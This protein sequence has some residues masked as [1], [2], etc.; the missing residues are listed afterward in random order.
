MNTA[1][2]LMAQFEKTTV[3]LEE[4]CEDYFGCARHTAIQKAKAGTLPVPAFKIGTGQ[5]APWFVHVNDL[6]VLIDK[7]RERA[8][9]EWI[10]KAA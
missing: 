6:A 3:L 8:K 1:L 7:Q 4:I 10:G 5:K 9:Q 2:L